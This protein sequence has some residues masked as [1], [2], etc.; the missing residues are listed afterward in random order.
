MEENNN[1]PTKPTR[2]SNATWDKVKAMWQYYRGWKW[3]IFIGLTFALLLSSYSVLIAKTTSVATLQ[4]GLMSQ[5]TIYAYDDTSAGTL[6]AQKGT[7]VPLEQISPQMRETLVAVEDKRFYEH[8]GFDTI[9]IGRAFVRLLINRDTSGGGGSTITQQLVKNAFLTLD[10]TFQRKIKELFLSIEVE[11]HY[12]KDQILEMYLNNS[13]YG[14][15]VWGIEDASQKYFGHP[16]SQLNYNESMVLTGTLKGPSIFNPIDDYEAAIERRNVVAQLMASDNVISQEDA[17]AIM[18]EGIYLYDNYYVEDSYTYPY[19]FD[20]VINEAVAVTDIPED[21]LLSK[22]YKIYT[23]L[24]PAYQ[25]AIDSSY[26]NTWI[27]P[28]DGTGEPLVQ[29]ASVVIDPNTGGIMAVYGGR[30]DYVYRG[31]NRATDMNRLPGSTLKPMAVYV[32]ALE[33]GYNMHSIV[34]DVVEGH[35]ANDYAPNN[36]NNYT[37]P[38]GE[39]E[40]YYALAQSKN[41][42]AVHLM[43]EIG[44]SESVRKLRQFG[45]NVPQENQ[46]LSLALGV[47]NPG[48]SPLQIANA[49]SAFA[50]EGIRYESSFI[51]RIE[52]ATGREVYNNESPTKH[53]VMTSNVA[54]DMTSMMLDTYGGYGTGY[55]SGPDFGMLAGKTGSTEVA[56]GNMDTRDRW[57]VGYTP[58][59]V[60]VS[61][62]GLDEVDVEGQPSLDELMPTGMGALFNLQTTGLMNQSPQTP[63]DVTYASQTQES[64]N[65]VENANNWQEQATYFLNDAGEFISEHGGNLLDEV[66]RIGSNVV[67]EVSGWIN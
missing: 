39:T 27:F 22:G 44:I 52:D 49:Y 34:P 12:T 17:N 13:Y 54:A 41:T 55:G 4:E 65:I 56:E 57:M 33:K 30:G 46:D 62:S 23:N 64:T 50:N 53:M 15:G 28:D 26:D 61:W 1:Q 21:D 47:I 7:Y 43:D 8:N 59:F 67:E 58:D 11:K 6:M 32:P 36:Y 9:G 37:E 63:F 25:N 18:A 20:G 48:L 35:G 51:R 2:K 31:F 14:N 60:I 38:G 45:I 5:T 42:T 3:L 16:A 19:Y 10:Q 66:G 24:N 29:S 40:L